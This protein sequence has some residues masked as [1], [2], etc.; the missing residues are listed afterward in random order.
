MTDI[1]PVDLDTK[2]YDID[3]ADVREITLHT[4]EWIA[5]KLL[6]PP[7]D[8]DGTYPRS[9]TVISQAFEN[10]SEAEAIAIVK[11]A[12]DQHSSD[13]NL[14]AEH[15]DVLQHLIEMIGEGKEGEDESVPPEDLEELKY[16]ACLFHHWS[17][18]Q[19][20][21][22]VTTPFDDQDEEC[23]TFRCYVIGIIWVG[24][25]AFVNQFFSPRQ[26]PIQLTVAVIQ[27]L[28]YPSGRL[29]QFIFPDWGFKVR[30]V[31][32]SL[33][34]GPWTQKEQ[35]LATLMA[36]VANVPPYIDYNIFVQYLPKFYNQPFALNFGYMVMMMLTTQFMGFGMV[37]FLR[38]LAVYPAK[39]MWP[40]LLP[41][42]AVNK[43]LL[44]PNRKEKINGWTMTRYTFFLLVSAIAFIQFWVPNYLFQAISTFNWMTW[45]A[46]NNV[47]LAA[48]TG[49]ASGLGFNPISSFDW[50]QF[51]AAVFPVMFMPISSLVLG[52][53]GMFVAGFIILAVWY[54]NTQYAG[55]LPIN[56]ADVF[57]NTGLPFNVSRILTNN[58]F[59]EAKYRAYSPPY[60]AAANLVVYGAFFAVYPMSFFYTVIMEWEI[61]KVSLRDLYDGF[62]HWKRSNYYGFDDYFSRTMSKYAEVPQWWYMVILLITFGMSIALIEHW[63]TKATVWMLVVV[64]L[65]NFVC[66]FPFTI[67]MSYTG[68][69]FTLNVLVELIV[70]YA[71]PG[72]GI[73]M[74]ILKAFS[75]QIQIQCQNFLTDQKV[76]HYGKLPPRSMFRVQ[77]LAT[78]VA[79]LVTLGVMQFQLNDVEHMC[80][81]KYQTSHEKFTCPSETVFFSASVIWAV[82]GPKKIFDSQYPIL[83]WC[84]LIGFGIALLFVFLQK[85]V[86]RMLK[87]R[88]PD[89]ASEITK[90]EARFKEV[91]PSIICYGFLNY[92]PYNLTYVW[93][94][95]YLAFFF[96]VYIRKRF[97][98]WWE[99]Y[100]YVFCS[101]MN[102]GIALSA[103]IIFFALQY[104]NVNLTW[105]GNTVSFAGVDGAGGAGI[106]PIPDK[107]FFGPD[108]AHYP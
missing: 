60:Y 71:L 11:K 46:P 101:A 35:L 64:M 29:W 93:S 3:T 63:N 27:L 57:D 62:K 81:V 42:L 50:N 79:G 84:F 92:A 105:W 33:N 108:S 48:I 67:V 78:I 104:T 51:T 97:P 99:K 40:T 86:P 32:Y 56:S 41:T 43:A 16:Q 20:V 76:G 34:P 87:K 90:W 58:E 49:G 38:K 83:R 24:I 13:A 2:E 68:I 44:A 55:Y 89:R 18:Y 95:V 25:A 77:M 66:L 6:I 74:M 8:V 94:G 96:N 21:R 53:S 17:P 103:I 59:D 54:T 23:E 45:I 75:V 39:A 9:V 19:Q 106:V 26:P 65:I 70:G 52:V 82:V 30:G 10:M 61:M 31:R 28:L 102:T 15:K 47:V 36:S 107:G 88:Y 22:S 73:A 72:K 37:G 1:K 12:W 4:E 100:T 85:F 5:Q 69:Q 91:N 14:T 80:D 7:S 98:G